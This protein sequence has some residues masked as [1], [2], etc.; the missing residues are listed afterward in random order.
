[1]YIANQLWCA[2][3]RRRRHATLGRRD[4][5]RLRRSGLRQW[6]PTRRAWHAALRRYPAD[7]FHHCA[8]LDRVYTASIITGGRRQLAGSPPAP[9][10]LT[11]ATLICGQRTALPAAGCEGAREGGVCHHVARRRARGAARRARPAAGNP[12]PPAAQSAR[13]ARAQAPHARRVHERARLERARL[14]RERLERERPNAAP[15][16]APRPARLRRLAAAPQQLRQQQ[17]VSRPSLVAP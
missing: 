2:R 10:P 15:S 9:C 8:A 13:H 6:V 3:V 7:F 17:R 11:S 12:P 4:G 1:M 5:D 16:A 14:E